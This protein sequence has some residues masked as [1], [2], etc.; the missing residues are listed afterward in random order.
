MKLED[1]LD[2]SN[3][4]IDGP[5]NGPRTEEDFEEV[6]QVVKYIPYIIYNRKQT[7]VKS[8]GIVKAIKFA[9]SQYSFAYKVVSVEYPSDI[10]SKYKLD[11]NV[12]DIFSDMKFYKFNSTLESA[13]K[14]YDKIL[15]DED[16]DLRFNK[17]SDVDL[18]KIWFDQLSDEE[19]EYVKIYFLNFMY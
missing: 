11:I 12:N 1:Y 2:S 15:N 8:A 5:V 16:N 3:K 19:K 6:V 17:L 9:Q 7:K 10:K 13:I 18:S 4:L 14:E